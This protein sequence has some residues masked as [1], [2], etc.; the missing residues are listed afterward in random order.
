[1]TYYYFTAEW[2]GPCKN[3]KPAVVASGKAT[4]IDVDTNR[5]MVDK[6]NIRSVPTVIGVIGDDV[7]ERYSGVE[8]IRKWVSR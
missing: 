7:R 2:C 4:I 5:E 1:M 8:E 3:V 6:F